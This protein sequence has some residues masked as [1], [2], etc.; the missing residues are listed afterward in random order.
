MTRS[1]AKEAAHRYVDEAVEAG[2]YNDPLDPELKPSLNLAIDQG[3]FLH[4]PDD[5]AAF[6]TWDLVSRE[7]LGQPCITIT[8]RE[9]EA[10]PSWE[11]WSA[12]EDAL[13]ESD[14][15]LYWSPAQMDAIRDHYLNLRRKHEPDGPEQVGRMELSRSLFHGC[16][17]SQA[18]A[19]EM[20]HFLIKLRTSNETEAAIQDRPRSMSEHIHASDSGGTESSRAETQDD[21]QVVLGAIVDQAADPAGATGGS[22]DLPADQGDEPAGSDTEASDMQDLECEAPDM[23]AP[24]IKDPE[25]EAPAT[26]DTE[27]D[28]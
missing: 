2:W 13:Y 4:P 15:Y 24:S 3:Y 10:R 12:V 16:F 20:A 25:F 21:P 17:S 14:W 1:K 5:A 11:V 19:E 23:E 27:S 18:A 9:L 8:F 22:E 28:S 7:Y 26:E 6:D